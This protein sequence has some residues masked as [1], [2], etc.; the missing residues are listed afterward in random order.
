LLSPNLSQQVWSRA[1]QRCEYCHLPAAVYPLPFQ[2]DHIIARQH[3]G[4]T[5]LENLALA[6]LHCNR[7]KGP[8]IAGIDPA[9]G[10]LVRLFHPRQDEWRMH[11]EWNVDELRGKTAI[12]GVTID[13]LAIND[14]EFRAVRAVLIEEGAFPLE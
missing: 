1:G 5:R 10:L 11:F 2:I 14:P 9:S 3:G 4:K 6:C 12:G 13:V 7:H 8:N